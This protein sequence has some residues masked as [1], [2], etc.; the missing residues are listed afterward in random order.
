MEKWCKWAKEWKL[1]V[2]GITIAMSGYLA[3]G[4]FTISYQTSVFKWIGFLV[5]A[6]TM[7]C[8]GVITLICRKREKENDIRNQWFAVSITAVFLCVLLF[9]RNG[10]FLWKAGEFACFFVLL[11]WCVVCGSS[12][13]ILLTGREWSVGRTIHFFKSHIGIILLLAAT[14]FLCL[15]PGVFQYK[16]DGLLYY[17]TC[18]ELHLESLS[19]LA[20]YG[21]IAQTFG[22]LVRVMDLII[23]STASAMLAVHLIMMLLGIA[24]FYAIVKQ[25]LPDRGQWECV[26]ITAIFAWSPYLLGMVHYYSLDFICQ[27]LLPPVIYYFMKKKWLLFS[28]FSLLFCF[29]KE[30]AIIV[31]G[32]LCVSAVVGDFVRDKT[33]DW[34]N[35]IGNLFKRKQYYIMV[36]PGILWI[37]TYEMLGP[38]NAGEGGF[39]IDILYVMNKLKNLYVLNFNWVFTIA[40]VIGIAVIIWKRDDRLRKVIF[41][42]LCMQLAFTVFSCLFKTVN[43]PRYNDTNQVTLYLLALIPTF[44]YTG[45][46]RIHKY[47]N[48]ASAAILALIMGMASFFTIDPVS[49]SLYPVFSVG[50]ATLITTAGVPFGDGM[51]YNR[52]MLDMENALDLAL[53]DAVVGDALVCFPTINDNPYYF[54]GMAEVA[55]IEE[56]RFDVEYWDV[57]KNTR[58]PEPSSD[59][60]EFTVYQLTDTIDW[61]ALETIV[62]RNPVDLIY[63]ADA[64][65]DYYAKMQ[66]HYAL[67][68]ESSYTYGGW[69][70]YRARFDM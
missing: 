38:W 29:T 14:F 26:S 16:W 64:G 59:T 47:I 15:K 52:Q 4:L 25:C 27:C 57:N 34:K 40:A 39:S 19:S 23:G 65:D 50:E 53:A 5:S 45:S 67:I 35:K 37:A 69:V 30:P 44:T 68:E 43:H 17:L 32:F 48:V 2:L 7:M 46:A 36:V 13:F 12:V 63:M 58:V 54:D 33:S 18:R 51:I 21:H 10:I 66:E 8:F 22:A 62:G 60:I 11:F 70:I 42:I 55:T 56:S 61:S 49:L 20:I 9:I 3:W 1:T 6:L 41:P 31:Y 28:V 24:Y